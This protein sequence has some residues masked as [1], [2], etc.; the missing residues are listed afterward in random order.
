MLETVAGIP[1]SKIVYSHGNF[2][3]AQCIQCGIEIEGKELFPTFEDGKVHQCRECT[4]AMKPGV[5]FFGEMLPNKFYELHE[6][7]LWDCDLLLIAGTSLKVFPV[8]NLVS[9]TKSNVP[10]I[11]LNREPHTFISK[12]DVYLP[13]DLQ[14]SISQLATELNWKLSE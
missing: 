14:L 3:T 1:E 11:V 4:G 7:D 10:R 6:N 5:V 2:A 13:D 9:L 12:E 8:A